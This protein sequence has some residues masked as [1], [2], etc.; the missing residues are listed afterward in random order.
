MADFL[1]ICFGSKFCNH[2]RSGIILLI[3]WSG[4]LSIGCTSEEKLKHKGHCKRHKLLLKHVLNA[5]VT[6]IFHLGYVICFGG[7]VFLKNNNL[8]DNSFDEFFVVL[9]QVQLPM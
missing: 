1:I 4:N 9:L 6:W 2:S 5:P 3:K 7:Q 8:N